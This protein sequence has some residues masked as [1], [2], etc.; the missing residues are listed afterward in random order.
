MWRL[1]IGAKARA[2][3]YLCTTNNYL[4]RQVWEFDALQRNLPREKK[5]EQKIPRAI[6]DDAN[7]ITYEDAKATL[8]R[9][10]LFM[11]ALQSHDGHW[12]AENAGCMFFN[13]PFVICLYI[14]GHLD[15]IFSQE[16][17]KEMLRY[18]YSH[19][20]FTSKST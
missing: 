19:Q 10:L 3:P 14:T 18:L 6:V 16:H 20:R 5:C 7:K 11:V 1:R 13:A 12:P 2:D 15:K 8:R 4:G 9:G 17:R